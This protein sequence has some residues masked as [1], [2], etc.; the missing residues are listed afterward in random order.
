MKYNHEI[1]HNGKP[2]LKNM[3]KTEFN[4]F[5]KSLLDILIAETPKQAERPPPE[6]KDGEIFNS[7]KNCDL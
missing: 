3:S 4:I 5:C 7:C 6:K 2:N 1:I